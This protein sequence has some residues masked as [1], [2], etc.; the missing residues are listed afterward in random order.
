MWQHS[1]LISSEPVAAM[2]TSVSLHPA[3]S[4]ASR[5]T[6]LPFRHI[7]SSWLDRRSRVSP[8]TSTMVT[9]CPSPARCSARVAPTFPAPAIMMV[10][11]N[12]LVS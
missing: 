6:Q 3:S 12:Q 2:S 1:R 7:T 10:K 9:L 5:D 11:S 4:S 8:D